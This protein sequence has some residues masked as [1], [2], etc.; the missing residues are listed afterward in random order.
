MV[1]PNGRVSEG[2]EGEEDEEAEGGE[3][4]EVGG[5]VEVAAEEGQG[6]SDGDEGDERRIVLEEHGQGAHGHEAGGRGLQTLPY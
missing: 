3:T 2:K 4:E 5:G 6:F 1:A